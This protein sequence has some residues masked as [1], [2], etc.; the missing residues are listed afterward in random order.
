MGRVSWTTRLA[1]PGGLDEAL[2]AS[3]P[4]SHGVV[5][6]SD[7]NG[8][9]IG[10]ASTGDMRSFVAQRLGA[11]AEGANDMRGV[12]ALCELAPA[13][14]MFEGDLVFMDAAL[15]REPGLHDRVTRKLR[16]WWLGTQ[17]DARRFAWQW[18]T[19]PTEFAPGS[20]AIGPFLDKSGAR[21]HAELLD[22]Q[23]ELCR[24]PEELHRAPAGKACVYKQMGRCP[25]A[26]DGSEPTEAFE[27]RLREALTFDR[28]GAEARLA[29]LDS[30]LREAASELAFERAAEIQGR[31]D[32]LARELKRGLSSVRRLERVK[33]I[34]VAA[35]GD[36]RSVTVL[37][38]DRG[39][40]T[41]VGGLAIDATLREADELLQRALGALDRF[42]GEAGVGDLGVLG[43]LS[44]ELMRPSRGG[45][46]L[47]EPEA[48][49]GALLLHAA[50]RVLRIRDPRADAG[51]DRGAPGEKSTDE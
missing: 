5:C 23:F 28:A 39:R 21:R 12:A 42:S 9:V 44:R 41:R 46:M 37:V 7:T 10:L 15:E 2:L 20:E 36:R 19:D 35:S 29:Q 40:W 11:M 33:Q 18:E 16:V 27:A 50:E 26:C 14:S 24:F 38:I 25:A 4:A 34:A 32:A 1:C 31:R 13:G 45:P 48:V 30:E 3:V 43:V 6:V 51:A 17:T 22:A 49:D 8:S 47:Y